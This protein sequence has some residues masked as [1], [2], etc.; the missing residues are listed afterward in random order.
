MRSQI[1]ISGAG[2]KREGY[3]ANLRPW[4]LWEIHTESG[5]TFTTFDGV[6]ANRAFENVG[7]FATVEYSLPDRELI[8][9]TIERSAA[10]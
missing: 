2:K 3:H 6:I 9:L 5:A 8:S 10:A 4:S 1:R 7:Q